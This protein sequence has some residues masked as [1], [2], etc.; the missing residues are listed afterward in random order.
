MH[1]IYL[2]PHP[3]DAALSCG[4]LA[5]EQ[6]HSGQEVSLWT[7][8]AGDPPAG[9]LSPFAESLHARWGTGR[10]ASTIRRAEDLHSC[11]LLGADA[12]HFSIP[13]CIYRRS[14]KT[15]AALYDSEEAIF[16]RIHPEEAVLV[17][18]A[19]RQIS[20]AFKLG[21]NVVCPLA[22][23]LHVDHR[24]VR[25]AAEKAGGSFWYYADYPYVLKEETPSNFLLQPGCEA[26]LFPISEAALSAW[27]A[28]IAAHTSQISTFWTDLPAMQASIENYCVE[29]G[30]VRLWRI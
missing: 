21:A 4:G 19:A 30:G 23:G 9:P 12:R 28:S 8:C 10:E 17:G 24:L 29:Q 11:A 5:W 26:S 2:S 25:A 15:G 6:A 20:Q 27:E 14:A 1:W 16:G 13:D 22:L 3:D 7:F 18:R